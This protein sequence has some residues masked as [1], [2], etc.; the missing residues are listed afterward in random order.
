[1]I[2]GTISTVQVIERIGGRLGDA[3][4]LDKD[5]IIKVER[6]STKV[7][8]NRP[9]I[10]RA[11]ANTSGQVLRYSLYTGCVRS[12]SLLLWLQLRAYP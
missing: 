10:I 1:M 6:E 11:R 4:Q 9:G 7:K 8:G 5:W 2:I 12:N 3:Y